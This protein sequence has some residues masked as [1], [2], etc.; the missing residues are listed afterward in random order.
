MLEGELAKVLEQTEEAK[1]AAEAQKEE[2]G[3]KRERLNS[4][5]ENFK[6]RHY[7][8]TLEHDRPS[9]APTAAGPREHRRRPPRARRPLRPAGSS[10]RRG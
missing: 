9:N 6:A 5:F 8:S 4:D 1:V 10:S 3:S 7:N 2:F